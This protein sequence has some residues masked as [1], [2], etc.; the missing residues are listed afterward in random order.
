MKKADL[1]DRWLGDAGENG[2]N[3]LRIA[4][5]MARVRKEVDE[6]LLPAAQVALA[7]NGALVL[8]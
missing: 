8:F 1:Q 5:L 7:R 6:G 4:A 2:V 3:P